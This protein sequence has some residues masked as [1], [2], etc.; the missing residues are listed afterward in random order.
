MDK[1][2]KPLLLIDVDGPLNPFNAWEEP[3]GYT[4]HRLTPHE[5]TLRVLLSAEHGP[6]LLSLAGEFELTWATSWG[7]DDKAN[8]MIAPLI[9]LPALPTIPVG[10]ND[11]SAPFGQIF[12][13]GPVED[14]ARGRPLAWF[15]DMFELGDRD[16]ATKRTDDGY[17]T[18]LIDIDPALGLCP[19]D[20]DTVARWWAAMGTAGD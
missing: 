6:M 1:P 16:W 4:A 14:Y 2:L 20:I 19:P 10:H 15:D 18:L 5:R 12:K 11:G 3:P 13:R 8:E 9:G 7:V 17:P